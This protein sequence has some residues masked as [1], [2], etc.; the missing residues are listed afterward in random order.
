M[1][2]QSLSAQNRGIAKM[3]ELVAGDLRQLGFQEVAIVGTKGHP[4][5]FGFHDAGAPRTLVVYM[6]YDV[7]LEDGSWKLEAGSWD[8]IRHLQ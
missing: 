8:E 2:Q 4:G 6:R 1:R 5:A 7:Q 3:A